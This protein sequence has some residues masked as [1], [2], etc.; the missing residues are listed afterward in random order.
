VVSATAQRVPGEGGQ[1]LDD[2]RA[3]FDSVAADYDGPRGNNALIQEMRAEVWRRLDATFA[4]GDTLLDL[5]CG[6]GLDAVRMARHGY[7]VLAT[8]FSSC[9]VERTAE[10]ARAER[11]AG[12]IEALNV[13]AHELARIEGAGTFD[14]AYSNFGALNC[15]P[16]LDC[17]ASEC[18][19]LLRP[20]AA[21]VLNVIGRVCP[22]EIAHYAGRGDF[23]RI[24]V[25]FAPAQVAVGLNGRRVW[26]RYYSPRE[27]YRRFAP[28][29]RL[30]DYRALALLAPPPYLTR[31]SERHP[32]T[33]ARLRALD[34]RIAAWPV[35]RNLGDHFL[36][37]M[38]RR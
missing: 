20:G 5:G 11:L 26:T 21:L 19:R 22:W 12:R 4:P 35:L 24:A 16:E 25:R 38:W 9:M 15:V 18:A 8:D 33:H 29:F 6:T 14:G 1:R 10:R 37:V 32:R 27:L 30:H 13:G 23:A 31:F 34:R 7:R 28:H 36:I 3:A 2:T 17:V